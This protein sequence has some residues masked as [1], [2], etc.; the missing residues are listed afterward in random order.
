[1]LNFQGSL[2]YVQAFIT[3][4]KEKKISKRKMRHSGGNYQKHFEVTFMTKLYHFKI[5]YPREVCV[6]SDNKVT[7]AFTNRIKFFGSEQFC[8][9]INKNLSMNVKTCAVLKSLIR[10]LPET[11]IKAVRPQSRE[12]WNLEKVWRIERWSQQ[13]V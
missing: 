7:T 1:M 2:N 6:F 11:T 10:I 3:K 9:N 4:E 12:Y 8:L 5:S 13:T